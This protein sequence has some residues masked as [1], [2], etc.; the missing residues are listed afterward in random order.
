[1]TGIEYGIIEDVKL[2]IED[3]SCL[4][5]NISCKISCGYIS[6]GNISLAHRN[7]P[8]ISKKH[9]KNDPTNYCGYF[10]T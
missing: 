5:L 6:F 8:F 3:H 7:E 4:V 2:Y 10:I 9:E 1:M